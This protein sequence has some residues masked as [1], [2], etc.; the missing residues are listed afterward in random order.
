M[1]VRGFGVLGLLG[2][3]TPDR[4]AVAASSGRLLAPSWPELL[5]GGDSNTN[6]GVP[7]PHRFAW[8]ADNFSGS[9]WTISCG[10][11]G[12]WVA[13]NNVASA[14]PYAGRITDSGRL[15]PANRWVKRL[16]MVGF[17]LSA[18]L[19]MYDTSPRSSPI[20]STSDVRAAVS[21]KAKFGPAEIPAD[22][23][24]P[25]IPANSPIIN[26]MS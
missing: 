10:R 26:P 22:C 5:N 23:H 21:S 20:I 13:T 19:M 8:P 16:M 6:R 17:T 1:R 24:P 15:N 12:A 4:L 11:P 18:P 3:V 7:A 14:S 25:R 2:V 9:K